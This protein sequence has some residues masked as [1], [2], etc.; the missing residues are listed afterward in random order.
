MINLL[1]KKIKKKHQNTFNDVQ[2]LRNVAV[3]YAILPPLA[4]D[5]FIYKSYYKSYV[6]HSQQHGNYQASFSS[7]CF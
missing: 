3:H 1:Q 2:V 6:T 4:Y 7:N 5:R